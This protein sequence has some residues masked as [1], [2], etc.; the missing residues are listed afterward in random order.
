MSLLS[1][2]RPAPLPPRADTRLSAAKDAL[3]HKK[4]GHRAQPL[5]LAPQRKYVCAWA[6]TNNMQ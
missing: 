3:V 6:R 5:T 2:I 1:E 4:R